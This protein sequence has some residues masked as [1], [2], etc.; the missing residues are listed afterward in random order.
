MFGP[1]CFFFPT[2]CNSPLFL[3]R[4]WS[5]PTFLLFPTTLTFP[6]PRRP[7]G[8][9]RLH[10]FRR[11]SPRDLVRTPIP[12]APVR[13]QFGPAPVSFL[14]SRSSCTVSVTSRSP[15]RFNAPSWC[16]P[17]CPPSLW[18]GVSS[19]STGATP[20]RL[21]TLS[22]YV[23]LSYVVPCI[24]WRAPDFSSLCSEGFLSISPPFLLSFF[25][26]FASPTF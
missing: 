5:N 17:A 23:R 9:P 4:G 11:S 2:A 16:Q 19:L 24:P 6:R 13:V 10:R 8:P 12:S 20:P 7:Q 3:L 26:L 14:L 15:H 25:F 1:D 18:L 21:C 22:P